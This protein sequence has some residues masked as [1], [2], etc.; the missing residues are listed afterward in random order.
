MSW[1]IVYKGGQAWVKKA[2]LAPMDLTLSRMGVTRE[3]QNK[4][5]WFGA[6]SLVV[7]RFKENYLRCKELVRNLREQIDTFWI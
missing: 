3:G 5:C 6:W 4:D 7:P 2:L 1:N